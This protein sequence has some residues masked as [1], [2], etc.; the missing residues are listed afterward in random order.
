MELVT[1]CYQCW[2]EEPLKNCLAK[3]HLPKSDP[4][5]SDDVKEFA[6]FVARLGAHKYAAFKVA[7]GIDKL[8]Y[9]AN[10]RYR[11]KFDRP[12]KGGHQ[13]ALKPTPINLTRAF[14]WA[15]GDYNNEPDPFTI[16]KKLAN[17][18]PGIPSSD[19]AVGYYLEQERRSTD[20]KGFSFQGEISR[21]LQQ[22]K[23]V[24]LT[25]YHA[26]IQIANFFNAREDLPG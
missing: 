15:N 18:F 10:Q 7:E 9:F 1:A 19:P 11:V 21:W 4:D 24:L 17:L 14:D 3:R 26:E 5:Y 25:R 20:H 6:H 16:V 22:K 2:F 8:P 23:G 13:E 12:P